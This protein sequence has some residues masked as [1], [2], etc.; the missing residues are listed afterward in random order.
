VHKRRFILPIPL[1]VTTLLFGSDS[2]AEENTRHDWTFALGLGTFHGTEYEGSAKAET[3]VF[4]TFEVAWND[5]IFLNLDELSFNYYKNESLILNVILSQGDEREENL[6][7]SFNGLGDIDSSTTLTLGAEFELGLFISNVALTKHNG[8]TNGIQAVVG[9]E[10]M[11]PLQLLT[12]NMPMANMDSME[13]T[14]ELTLTGPFLT[15]ALTMEW[16]DNDYINGFFG[17]DAVQSARSGLPQYAAAAG[18]RSVNL[19]LGVLHI[20]DNSW[21]VQGLAGYNT[22]IGDAKNS[23]I[24][25][26]DDFIYFAGFIT[27]HF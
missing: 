24:V 13:D 11:L 14:E 12:G 18:F 10:T 21:T 19:D 15:A 4:P 26:D 27:Y 20:I 2:S 16:A 23:P 22:L 6:N 25:R 5:T 1:I 7:A 8:G 3:F 9:I 17:V